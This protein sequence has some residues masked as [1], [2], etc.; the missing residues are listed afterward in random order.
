MK[1]ETTRALADADRA[2]RRIR[3][4][5][6]QAQTVRGVT[7]APLGPAREPLIAASLDAGLDDANGNP[8]RRR[9]AVVIRRSGRLLAMLPRDARAA[10]NR[11]AALV[12]TSTSPKGASLAGGG[13]SGRISDGGAVA[14]VA[15]SEEVRAMARRIGSGRIAAGRVPV[16]VVVWSVAVRGLGLADTLR[17]AGIAN[18]TRRDLVEA[19]DALVAALD[20]IAGGMSAEGRLD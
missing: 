8:E 16:L 15:A 1:N 20:R 11:L 3:R 7:L 5:T 6:A 18:P 12:E 13:G 19:R 14:R 17:E 10:A 2:I 4:R 9:E